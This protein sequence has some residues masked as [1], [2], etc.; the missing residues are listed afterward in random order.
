MRTTGPL[1]GCLPGLNALDRKQKLKAL[2]GLP[3]HLHKVL[4]EDDAARISVLW[5]VICTIFTG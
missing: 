5:K 4:P 2:K 1:L 3:D